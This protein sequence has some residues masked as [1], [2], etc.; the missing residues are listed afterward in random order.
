MLKLDL[1]NKSEFTLLNI[2]DPQLS[3]GEWENGHKSGIILKK[4]VTDV[5]ERSH[6]DFITVSGDIS[7]G[8][9]LQSYIYFANFMD[10][11]GIPWSVCFGN[12][13]NQGGEEAINEVVKEYSK[14]PLFTYES[15]DPALGNGN[16]VLGVY[17][18]GKPLEALI[19]MDTHDRVPYVG[20]NGD[21]Y[22]VWAKVSPE[23]LIW[24]RSRIDELEK[25]G[26]GDSIM[27]SHIP[28][29][30]YR[31]AFAAAARADIDPNTVK[32]ENSTGA[33]FWN[34]GYEDSYGV[35][36]EDICSYPDEDG[37]FAVIKEKGHTKTLVA[38]HDHIN[39]FVIDYEGVKFVYSLKAGQGCYWTPI[40]NGGTVLTFSADGKKSVRHEYVDV[41]E[42][43]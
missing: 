17:L 28:I 16:F 35:K 7:Y 6:P 43:L 18:D 9:D 27:I 12:H 22:P 42:L 13:D 31:Q 36:Y 11:Y 19:M 1:Q 8:G 4:T 37:A 38:G 29:Y 21:E 2:S 14:H 33:D 20:E 30:A 23:Q 24:Y 10:S 39:N 40:L 25:A 34:P 3:H 26:F 41:S 15:G 32:P 5:I